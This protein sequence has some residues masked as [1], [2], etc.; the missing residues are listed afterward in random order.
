MR[1]ARGEI[2]EYEPF[3]SLLPG[4]NYSSDSYKFGFNG[5]MKDDEVYGA[6]GTSY[7]AEFWQY[8]ARVGR[9][10][11]LDPVPQMSISDYATFG[12][13]PILNSDPL[14]NIWDVSQNKQSK[15]DAQSLVKA[16]N[17]KYMTFNNGRVGLDFGDMSKDDIA[18]LLKKDEGL[19]LVNDLVSSDKKKH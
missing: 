16:D 8:D 6:T 18:G 1:G 14:G 11:N 4:K 15:A 9:R 10:W 7:T 17:Q 19:S 13:N 5:Q 2:Q 3:G 12:L